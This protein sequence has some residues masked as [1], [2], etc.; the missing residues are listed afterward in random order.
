MTEDEM[1]GWNHQLN[2]DDLSNL[3]ELVMVS[4]KLGMLQSLG[5]QRV[6]Y[7]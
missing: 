3:W 7:D 2:I 6:G 4:G 5:S 1:V